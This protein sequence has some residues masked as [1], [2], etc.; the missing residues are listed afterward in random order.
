MAFKALCGFCCG[1][2]IFLFSVVQMSEA[3]K[4]LCLGKLEALLQKLCVNRF[5]AVLTGAAVTGLIQ[6]SAAVTV[7]ATSLVDCGTLSASQGIGIIMGSNI[8][9]TVTGVL[10]A[11]N[12]S[13]AAPFIVL[14]GALLSLFSKSEKLK[15]LGLFFCA[16]SLLFVGIDT[17]K[18]AAAALNE[19]GSLSS[20]FSLCSS[21]FTGLL[22]GFASTALLQSSSATVGI[23]QSLVSVGA[24]GRKAAIFIICGQNIGATVPT[25]LSAL[26]SNEKAKATALFHLLFNFFGTA[27]VFLLSLFIPVEVLFSKIGD[28]AAFVSLFHLLFNAAGTAAVFPFSLSL[29]RLSSALTEKSTHANQLFITK[30][31]A[32]LKLGNGVKIHKNFSKFL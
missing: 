22:F 27:L 11:L 8:G 25:L 15:S 30:I 4:K 1:V 17:M 9:T 21:K 20:L 24:V 29:L 16:L 26:H 23:L 2:G 12:F 14:F 5:F 18:Q 7:C 19:N 31:K 13:A 32:L 6:S 28:G 10:I 3:M